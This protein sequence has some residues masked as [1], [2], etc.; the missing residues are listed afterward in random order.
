MEESTGVPQ[1]G[2]DMLGRG[3][4][5]CVFK[6]P[7]TCK[8][9]EEPVGVTDHP[10]KSI[11]KLAT[12]D[13]AEHEIVIAKRIQSLPLWKNY[14]LVAESI[15]EPAAKQTDPS[16]KDCKI[17]DTPIDTAHMGRYRL[18]RMTYGGRSLA[19]MRM[20][21]AKHSFYDFAK[22]L[23]E[24]GAILT[25]VGLVHM[26][27]H[28]ANVV[29]DEMNVPRVIDFNLA[30][31]V[32]RYTRLSHSYMPELSQISPDNSLVKASPEIRGM[33]AIQDILKNKRSIGILTAVLGVPYK[34]QQRQLIQF[35]KNSRSIQQG[36]VDKW[37]KHYWRVQDSWAIGYLLTGLLAEMSRWPSFAKS[38]YASYSDKLLPVLRSMCALS[39]RKRF[40]CV[41]ALE[42]LEPTHYFFKNYP[43]MKEWL[44]RVKT[45]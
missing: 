5:G 36:N 17:E 8:D 37:F 38:D 20:D 22:H 2:G 14:Y 32:K 1:D 12:T 21:F 45:L 4:Y 34:E 33:A 27:L 9:D 10:M 24:A 6:P 16:Y 29:V 39:P 19:S 35:Y 13:A 40:D 30:V 23:I 31:D 7:L 25:L 28:G 26:D 15:C 42:A 3:S 18:L 11:S 43:K 44:A 41:Q